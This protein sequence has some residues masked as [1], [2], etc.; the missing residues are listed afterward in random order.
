[1][2]FI[3]LGAESTYIHFKSISASL[4]FEA[5]SI[6]NRKAAKSERTETSIQNSNR[7]KFPTRAILNVLWLLYRMKRQR[8]IVY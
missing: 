2:R 6:I 1:M 4:Q 7:Y 3:I 5:S 8:D